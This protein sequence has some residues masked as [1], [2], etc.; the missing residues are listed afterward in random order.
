MSKSEITYWTG[1]IQGTELN[2]IDSVYFLY[3]LWVLRMDWLR[4]NILK[5]EV[6]FFFLLRKPVKQ[7]SHIET[8]IIQVCPLKIIFTVCISIIIFSIN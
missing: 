1:K 2:N 3:W 5:Y 7:Y 4:K 8:V 6:S